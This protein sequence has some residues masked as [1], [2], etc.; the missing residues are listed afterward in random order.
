MGEMG[1]LHC[2][3][4]HACAALLVSYVVCHTSHVTS[5]TSQVTRHTPPA[6]TQRLRLGKNT[7]SLRSSVLNSITTSLHAIINQHTPRHIALQDKYITVRDID[8]MHTA[9]AEM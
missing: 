5:H 6:I 2:V 4:L 7:S 3:M 8:T 1:G 9:E